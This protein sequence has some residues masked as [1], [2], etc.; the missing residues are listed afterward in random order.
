MQLIKK[1]QFALFMLSGAV[2]AAVATSCEHQLTPSK[3]IS[4][5]QWPPE[6]SCGESVWPEIEAWEITV[7]TAEGSENFSVCADKK[8]ITLSM[9]S[10]SPVSLLARPFFSGYCFFKPAGM[11]FPFEEEF[12]WEAGFSSDC[13]KKFYI[14]AAQNNP[15]N[16]A[17]DYAARFNWQKIT[18][19]IKNNA[20]N[21]RAFYNPWLLDQ[22]GILASIEDRTFTAAKLSMKKICSVTASELFKDF[23]ENSIFSDYV[24]QN[25]CQEDQENQENKIFTLSQQK[26]NSFLF[27]ENLKIIT[28]NA[29]SRTSFSL[30]INS[31][32]I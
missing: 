12:S 5:P 28:V 22:P 6:C 3:E 8:S 17:R 7:T 11:I 21:N 23:P 29:K 9:D 1:I 31:V 10:S 25:F 18:L 19:T 30:A 15:K 26:L 27:Y 24:P 14:S 20:K 32:P 13:L 2:G 4:L 16:A